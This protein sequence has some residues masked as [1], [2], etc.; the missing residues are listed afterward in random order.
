MTTNEW[1]VDHMFLYVHSVCLPVY[2]QHSLHY[3]LFDLIT[4]CQ[5]ISNQEIDIMHSLSKLKYVN[6][7]LRQYCSIQEQQARKV[8]SEL[9]V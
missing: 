2:C 6:L 5:I 3:G 9:W 7:H 8:M 1:V 4:F